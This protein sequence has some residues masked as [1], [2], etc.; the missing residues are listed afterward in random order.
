MRKIAFWLLLPAAGLAARPA[1]ASDQIFLT[2]VP[3][4]LSA[5][6]TAQL[7]LSVQVDTVPFGGYLFTL[8]Y[9]TRTLTLIS[10]GQVMSGD[11]QDEFYQ[12]PGAAAGSFT[13]QGLNDKSLLT[14]TGSTSLVIAVFQ[15]TSSSA[16]FGNNAILS[17][18]VSVTA[19]EAVS[20]G[21][22]TVAVFGAS[23]SFQVL[24][25]TV[26][27]TTSLIVS[28][29]AQFIDGLGQLF[30][31]SGTL[32]GFSATDTA[33]GSFP[34]SGVAETDYRVDA[35]TPTAP[36][37]AF[38]SPFSLPEGVHLIEFRSIDRSGNV[39][40]TKSRTVKVDATPPVTQIAFSTAVFVSS[41]SGT[42]ISGG[43][44]IGFTAQDPVSNGVTSG[45]S[46]VQFRV[47]ASTPASPFQAFVSSFSLSAGAHTIDYRSVDNV[48]NMES[49]RSTA[50][51]VDTAA[52]VTTLLVDGAPAASTSALVLVSTD[53]LSLSAV[54]AGSG[55]QRTLFTLDA[56]APQVYASTFT[57][58][59]GT[60]TLA[61]QS[62]DNVGNLEASRSVAASV[63]AADL[64]PPRTSLLV[65]TPS[66]SSAPVYVTNLTTFS[67]AAVDDRTAVGDGAGTGVARSFVAIDT[68]TF[69]VYTGTF[70]IAAEGLH[71]LSFYSTDLAG[72]VEAAH[73]SA[74]A[75]DLTA[76]I[77]TLSFVGSSS[78]N[79]LG[80]LFVSS[81]TFFTLTSTDPVSSAVASGV[82]TVFF[83]IDH[84]PSS[85]DCL[86]VPL[87]PNAPPGTCANEA[88]NGAFT[89]APGTHTVYYFA[90][91]NVGNSEIINF[92]ALTVDGL[93]PRTSLVI[94]SP[95][96]GTNPV[97]VSTMT[98][99]SLRVADDAATVGDGIG[100]GAASTFIAV[101]TAPFS[102]Y[103]GSFTVSSPGAHTIQSYSIDAVGNAEAAHAAAVTVDAAAPALAL[104]PADGDRVNTTTPTITAFYSDSGSGVNGATLRVSLDGVDV[105]TRAVVTASSATFTPA[106]LSQGTHTVTASVAD[107]LGNKASASATFLVDSI[108]PMTTLVIGSPQFVSGTVF[109]TTATP[110][111]F[112]TSQPSHTSYAIDGGSF[113]VFS[114]T[115]TLSGAGLHLIRYFSVDLAGNTE[116][117]RSSTV[118]VDALPPRTAF[119]AGT[120]SFSSGTLYAS[121][122]TTFSLAAL[123]DLAAVGDGLGSG[124]ARTLIAI[125]SGAFTVYPGTFSIQTEGLHA[126]G[127]FSLDQLGNAEAAGSASVAIDLTTPITTLSFVGASTKNALGTLF[128]SS[129]SSF[130]LT[131]TD[132]VSNGVASGVNTIFFVIDHDP[133][134]ADCQSVPLDPNAPPGTCAN[135]AYNGAFTLAPG[136]HTVYYFAEDN[137]GNSEIINVT[138]LTIDGL[139]PR[140]SLAIGLPQ[141][142]LNPVFVSTSTPLTLQAADDA[143]LVG[144]GIGA[145]VASTFIAIDTSP[146]AL[147]S[148]TFT[149]SAQG[150]H[151][152]AFYSVDVLGNTEAARSATVAVDAAPPVTQL[153]VD[154]NVV[155]STSIAIISTD[156]LSLAAADLGSGVATTFLTI[157][158]GLQQVYASTFSLTAGTHTVAFQSRD[159]VANLEAL[160]IVTAS[161]RGPDA[162]PPSLT[163]A[164][165]NGSTVTTVTPAIVAV[166]SDFGTGV[167]TATFRLRL[168]GV[169]VTNLAVV[170]PS[171]AVFTPAAL[172][173]ATHTVTA[174]VADFAGNQAQASSTFLV[175]S[176]PPQTTLLINGTAV[177]S[178][179]V[180]ITPTDTISFTATDAGSG[181]LQTLFSLDQAA[182]QVFSSS[183]TVAVG[184]HTLTFQSVDRAGNV[185]P[186]KSEFLTVVASSGTGFAVALTLDPATI[187]LKSQG[188][189]E[190][191]IIEVTGTKSSADIAPTSLKITA[192]NG[193]PLSQPITALS[194]PAPQLGDANNNGILDLSVKFDRSALIA[195]LPVEEQVQVTISGL[196]KDSSPLSASTFVRTIKPVNVQA[197]NGGTVNHMTTS[198]QVIVPAGALTQ[199]TDI[200]ITKLSAAPPADEQ[201][202]S[203]AA[204]TAGLKRQGS[205]YDFG[206]DGTQFSLSAT[207]SL[208]YDPAGPDPSV[209]RIAY[210][211]AQTGRWEP[212]NSTFDAGLRMISAKTSHFSIYQVVAPQGA[213][214]AALPAA[215]SADSS[216]VFRDLYAF[217]NPS[218]HGHAVTI[219]TQVGLADT[220]QL[221]IYDVSGHH[222]RSGAPPSPQV[223]DDGNGKGPQW[224]YDYVW[225]TNGAGSGIYIFTVTAKKAGLPAIVKSAKAGVLK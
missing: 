8:N 24:G 220:V 225:D 45:I 30:I 156:T 129:N 179:S 130:T 199:D 89:L 5:G 61:F 41:S 189:F 148:G 69:S 26:A 48:A 25:D 62:I 96:S 206:P 16:P 173:Q 162:T 171:S 12:G 193:V 57:L 164:P 223:L 203:D 154:G 64:L 124:V 38:V 134:S 205:P 102:P 182:A 143:A 42:F 90:D 194:Q 165:V 197:A 19:R 135:E 1:A 198:A 35:S 87:D 139:P 23:S 10:M 195:V 67:L 221:D 76:P 160:K 21:G 70:S 36:F 177:A 119:V 213:G 114:G 18:T 22:S 78:T 32:L 28:T 117:V 51:S 123:D 115:F 204:Q 104:T 186:L 146:F 167:N 153:L 125:D 217:P 222:L 44:T 133:S 43:T 110:L 166:Y 100:A 86:A 106:A 108:A 180:T 118:A 163:L 174:S 109:I 82:N 79:T 157:D 56:G 158:D 145:G 9:D 75:V 71:T 126:V 196:F 184:T 136:T 216:F 188:Q 77:T 187:N 46:A 37:Q 74:A 54:D 111:R 59:V 178:S 122:I 7:Q 185:E 34:P 15:A 183:F 6:A 66:F 93:P 97:Y 39:E 2:P 214:T 40:S 27:P 210:W 200:T 212:L 207:L 131:S 55:V 20:T 209:L 132:P 147:Y 11:F 128:V 201:A 190:A 141:F 17:G 168:D 81:G 53:V 191:A 170:T 161:V 202:R 47:D 50:L 72:N 192:I 88:Y 144:D 60:H 33:V 58:A 142:G 121:N 103:V 149:L 137:V 52:P 152:I 4:T 68:T 3:A 95:Q 218:K 112:T 175:D 159:N 127:F 208:P 14:P 91:D 172:S 155:S 13:F 150:S 83:V 84:D 105:T 116:A 98:P 92:T 138:P 211:N 31:A 215:A 151:T 224:S 85:P 176:V 99:L 65:G 101:D 140:T 63:G 113:T 49:A 120:P 219:R 80:A 73:S 94:G 169:D 107:N 181:V 29:G